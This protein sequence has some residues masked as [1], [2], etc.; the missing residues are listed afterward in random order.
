MWNSW[1]LVCVEHKDLTVDYQLANTLTS[2]RYSNQNI[3]SEIFAYLRNIQNK[4]AF[5]VRD[6][7]SIL[8]RRMTRVVR[9]TRL[10]IPFIGS[11]KNYHGIDK[12]FHRIIDSDIML[13]GIIAVFSSIFIALLSLTIASSSVTQNGNQRSWNCWRRAMPKMCNEMFSFRSQL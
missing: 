10:K 9:Q 4:N 8:S 6:S 11:I 12:D 1:N 5:D 2:V 13:V 3:Y 7:G